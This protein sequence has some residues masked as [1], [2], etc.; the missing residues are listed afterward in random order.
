MRRHCASVHIHRSRQCSSWI[1]NHPYRTVFAEMYQIRISA[2]LDYTVTLFGIGYY[3]NWTP[4]HPQ[5][6]LSY[7]CHPLLVCRRGRGR[8]LPLAGEERH[9]ITSFA[10]STNFSPNSSAMFSATIPSYFLVYTSSS[11]PLQACRHHTP[12]PTQNGSVPRYLVPSR[13]IYVALRIASPSMSTRINP[14]HICI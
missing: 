7:L 4:A 5:L 12:T 13:L 3:L 10:L 1:T 8:P 2:L 14:L 6:P 11:R 9:T